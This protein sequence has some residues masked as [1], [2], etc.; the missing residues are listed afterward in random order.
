[1][2]GASS[3]ARL[4]SRLGFLM[5]AAGCAVGLGNVWR[6]P[7]IVGQNGGAAF[8]L[9]YLAFLV[10][11]GF[12][13]L[14]A[15]LAL[16]RASRRGISGAMRELAAER[17]RRFW[18]A[19]GKVIFAGNFLLMI[20]YTDVAGWLLKY[21]GDYLRGAGRTDFAALVADPATCTCHLVLAVAAA[22]AIC[23]LGVQKGVERV[24][25]AMMI[26]LLALLGVLAAKSLTLPGAAEGL[27]FYLAPD[28]ARFAAHP[29]RAV[30]DAMGQAFFTLS[31]GVGCMTIFGSYIGRERS[32]A[33]ESALIIAIDT[34]VAL[35]AGLVVFPACASFGVDVTSGPGLIFVAL[36]DVFAH[37]AGGRVWGFVF[38]LFLS[39][40]ALTTIV[41]VFEC[42]IGGLADE[43]GR[44]RRGIALAVGAVVTV[45]SLPTVLFKP[46]LGWEDF[47]FGQ[48]WLPLGALTIC[49][50]VTRRFGWGY[51][52]FEKEASA[53]AGMRFPPA[54][55]AMMK[56]LVPLL[57]LATMAAGLCKG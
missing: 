13:L 48:L 11:L 53:G 42:I 30:F 24:T 5:P 31:T 32:L 19:A 7:F 3:R 52:P 47:V 25:K 20:Y 27:R 33:T 54:F 18:S 37:M 36:P 40:A 1:M 16:G 55:G 57:I 12:P 4:K 44:P 46:V 26:A 15:E 35:L 2:D 8:V 10:L 38:F 9:V 45:L 21:S 23:M 49:I 56:V 39:L 22:T 29:W 34:L 14:T 43:L 6:F 28:W 17:H 50:F 51:E 41:A